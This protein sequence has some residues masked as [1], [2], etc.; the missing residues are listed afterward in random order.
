[1]G[2]SSLWTRSKFVWDWTPLAFHHW[3]QLDWTLFRVDWT[4]LEKVR[5]CREWFQHC[6]VIITGW[7]RVSSF[8]LRLLTVREIAQNSSVFVCAPTD[9]APTLKYAYIFDCITDSLTHTK[10]FIR[11]RNIISLFFLFLW[12]C[13]KDLK[14]NVILVLVYCFWGVQLYQGFDISYHFNLRL[15]FENTGLRN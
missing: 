7:T 2:R 4:G 1:M 14:E 10:I 15:K 6:I 9:W 8:F 11:D 5:L 13:V 12:K 3:T